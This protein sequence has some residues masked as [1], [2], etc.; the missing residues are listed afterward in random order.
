[1]NSL[2]GVLPST[3]SSSMNVL[4]PVITLL[5]M[6]AVS[7]EEYNYSEANVPSYQLPDALLT[8]GGS[9]VTDKTQWINVRRSELLSLLEQEMFGKSP[10]RPKLHFS[11]SENFTPAF[12]GK[13]LRQQ[14]T[15]YFSDNKDGPFVDVLL[16]LPIQVQ[17]PAPVIFGLNFLGNQSVAV[18]PAIALCRS[19]VDNKTKD[20]NPALHRAQ[21]SSR[22]V[23][24][25]KWQIEYA[26]SRGYGV[27]TAYYGDIDPDFDDQWKNG[28]HALFP[29]IEKNRD[30]HSWG[31]IAAWAWGMSY[32]MDYLVQEKQVDSTR[33]AVQGFSRL[34]KAALWAG[35]CDTRF[36]VVISQNSGAGGAALN[37]RIFGETV[38]RLNTSFPHWFCKQFH[39]YSLNEAAMPFDSHELLALIAPRPLLITSA[40]ED[41]W[42]DPQ[43]EFLAGKAASPVYQLLGMQ[44]LE[45]EQ[46]PEPGKLINSRIG[47][48]LRKGPHSVTKDDWQAYGDFC[49]HWQK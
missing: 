46:Q 16:Y 5:V 34:G 19:W 22:G 25:E 35:A 30:A 14:V 18:D 36:A 32:V 21:E 12:N 45:A 37:K 26:I 15:L 43:G 42:S 10:A 29:E 40:T 28:V 2:F 39:H 27:V 1:M 7:A 24:A 13:A 20:S 4:L 17:H 44:G 9:R 38:N 49:D 47:Y 11:I 48:F 3:Y 33:V 6:Y 31:S 41:R 8:H 23:D